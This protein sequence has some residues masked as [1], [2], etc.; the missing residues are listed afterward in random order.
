MS[1]PLATYV[2]DHLGGAQIALQVL[3]AM[4]DQHEDKKF[5]KFAES[6]LPEIQ[7][8]DNTLR[9][10]T[11][12]I[13]TNPSVVKQLGG[14]LMEK[15]ARIKLGHTGSTNFE[16]FESLELL[17]LGIHGKLCL[18]KA[19]EVA[20]KLDSRLRE[21][22][23]TELKS[24]AEQQYDKVEGERLRLAETVLSPPSYTVEN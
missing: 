12:K 24:R 20:S 1:E 14:W 18:W 21:Y 9:S 19:L 8:D 23:F 10:I 6:L 15:A 2:N 13:G 3:E 11:E 22:N 16:M 5:R 7:G 17:A 4:R